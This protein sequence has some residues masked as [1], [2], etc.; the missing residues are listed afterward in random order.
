LV[1]QFKKSILRGYYYY[2][3]ERLILE[4][5][6]S[7]HLKEPPVLPANKKFEVIVLGLDNESKAINRKPHSDIAGQIKISGDIFDSVPSSE[8]NFSS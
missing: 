6:Q 5:D 4:T 1:L 3:C 8:W 2:V 7:G